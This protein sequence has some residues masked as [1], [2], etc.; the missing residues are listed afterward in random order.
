MSGALF[1]LASITWLTIGYLAGR[2]AAPIVYQRYRRLFP[3]TAS[4]DVHMG[5]V[6]A[7]GMLFLCTILGPFGWIYPLAFGTTWHVIPEIRDAN[8]E[9]EAARRRAELADLQRQIDEAH[10]H[11]GIAPLK[12]GA[13]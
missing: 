1:A 5:G 7:V 10:R 9:V 4:R 11:L 8:R 6:E 3:L 13:S 2:K 12:R